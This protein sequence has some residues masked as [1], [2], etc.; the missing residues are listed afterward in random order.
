MN[1]FL[2]VSV[3]AFEL[4]KYSDFIQLLSHVEEVVAEAKRAKSRVLVLPELVCIGLLWLDARACLVSNSGIGQLYR[5]V[6]TPLL[7]R[8]MLAMS[9]IAVENDIYIVGASFWHEENGT[10]KNSAFVFMP[11]GKHI[12]QD[13]IH[14]TRG[15]R[16]ISTTGGRDLIP[17]EIDGVKCGMFTCYDIQF[18]ELTRHLVSRH[19]VEAIFVPSLTDHR[20]KW[21]V[22]YSG[23]ARA[24]ENQCFICVST[25]VGPMDIPVDYKS[26]LQGPPF[27]AS[28]ID[29]RF[30]IDD[31]NISIGEDKPCLISADLNIELLR[32]SR[33]KSEI[34]QL[35]DRRDDVY[36]YLG[37]LV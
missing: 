23:H 36:L 37:K 19:G 20:G 30:A 16:A 32:K 24:I 35:A 26:E 1:P 14:M 3:A 29:N 4:R 21:R 18:P 34:R 11:S 9:K 31:G 6:L 10:G 28:P 15:E 2:K 7:P 12:R 17:F 5:E 27:V 33:E 25:L 8:Y 22:Y 13:K